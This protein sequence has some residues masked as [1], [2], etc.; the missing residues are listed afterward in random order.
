[1]Y[2]IA[3][4]SDTNRTRTQNTMVGRRRSGGSNLPFSFPLNSVELPSVPSF[5]PPPVDF[6]SKW[7]SWSE[8]SNI[9]AW[10]IVSTFYTYQDD[11]TVDQNWCRVDQRDEHA[12]AVEILKLQKSLIILS[13]PGVD[14]LRSSNTSHY[15]YIEKYKY[16]S[17]II[18]KLIKLTEYD[19]KCPLKV[20]P[21]SGEQD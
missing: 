11:D 12:L 16:Y 21:F 9:E 13:H 15:N 10:I 20:D 14:L 8:E 7:T 17:Q 2:E 3:T 19:E 5:S 1:M 4:I 18:I 6:P